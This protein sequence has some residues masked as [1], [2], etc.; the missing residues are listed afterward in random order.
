METYLN[1]SYDLALAGHAHGG[2]WRIPFLLNGLYAPNQ[3]IF[4][5]YA[6]GFYEFED[7]NL[8]VSRGLSRENQV[9][10]RLFNRPELVF[11]NIT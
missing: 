4:P 8:V 9:I 10:P 5:P 6:G 1:Y 11:I 2:Q 3:G 7:M